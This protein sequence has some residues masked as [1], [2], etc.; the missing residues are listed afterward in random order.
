MLKVL[1][2]E[3]EIKLVYV[4]VCLL[5]KE[6]VEEKDSELSMVYAP[7]SNHIICQDKG[8]KDTDGFNEPLRSRLGFLDLQNIIFVK[9][10]NTVAFVKFLDDNICI[11]AEIIQC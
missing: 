2:T 4:M 11:I 5:R 3:Q 7:W 10:S 8:R 6:W 9:K 1:A